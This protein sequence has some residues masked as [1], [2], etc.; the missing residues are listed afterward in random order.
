MKINDIKDF[1]KDL[2]GKVTIK[3]NTI[4]ESEAYKSIIE[5]SMNILNKVKEKF[6]NDSFGSTILNLTAGALF[7]KFTK[8][9]ENCKWFKDPVKCGK[10]RKIFNAI[11]KMICI[12]GTIAFAMYAVKLIIALI[13]TIITFAATVFGVAIIFEVICKML[14]TAMNA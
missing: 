10:I 14:K 9:F 1:A 2:I 4:K 12:V 3:I 11:F 7:S 13:P 8:I 5:K 6:T